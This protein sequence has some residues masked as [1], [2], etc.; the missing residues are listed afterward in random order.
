[1]ADDG[2]RSVSLP[3]Y[4]GG[5]V[6]N[7]A[8]VDPDCMERLK[9]FRLSQQEIHGYKYPVIQVDGRTVKL[10]HFLHGAPPAGQVK[11]TMNGDRMDNRIANLRDSTFSERAQ[12]KI[13][14]PGAT[15]KYI[16]VS[17]KKRNN[18]W[19]VQATSPGGKVE[20]LGMVQV[21]VEGAKMYDRHVLK[22]RGRDAK[23]NGVL[24]AEETEAIL[25]GEETKDEGPKRAPRDLPMGVYRVKS[26]YLARWTDENGHK[27]SKMYKTIQEANSRYQRESARVQGIKLA[28]QQAVPVTRNESGEPVIVTNR[29][30]GQQR[31]VKVPEQHWE[32]LNRHSWSWSDKNSNPKAKI[33]G[34]YIYIHQYVWQLEHPGEDI[35]GGYEMDH[36]DWDHADCR[37]ES[38]RLV[39]KGANCQNKRKR[40]GASSKYLGV[41][42]DS[43][44][45]KWQ[46]RIRNDGT[47][48]N[49]GYH[50][51][52]KS[53]AREYN[54]AV[55]EAYPDGEG[56]KNDIS[57]DEDAQRSSA[58]RQRRVV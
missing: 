18:K 44:R 55:D 9:G 57:D 11:T 49:R 3:V 22:T 46:V 40:E 34:K 30:R 45:Q 50:G 2:S 52:E 56:R 12:K 37:V 4:K 1:M 28:Q 6:V 33:N 10:S 19:A 53:A 5:A 27:Q 16:G 47:Q 7:H 23:V 8:I 35:P 54:A 15:S 41:S 24:S 31:E 26:G 29:H 39:T 51:T 20:H 25:A 21:P 32:E 13:K 14:A 58:K 43:A 17:W 42:Y 36:I 38:L 48:T